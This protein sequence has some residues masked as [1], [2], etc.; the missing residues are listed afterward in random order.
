[1]TDRTVLITIAGGSIVGSAVHTNMSM[2]GK[3]FSY[4]FIDLSI[5]LVT[6]QVKQN[7]HMYVKERDIHMY[8][9]ER[10]SLKV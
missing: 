10:G 7:I 9:R 1:M 2:L 6:E 4:L 8:L 3:N 5:T